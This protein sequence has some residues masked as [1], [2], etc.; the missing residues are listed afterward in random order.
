MET[1]IVAPIPVKDYPQNW[2]DF[3]DWFATE[4]ACLDYLE[5]LRWAS[6]FVCPS[7]G[8]VAE[9]Y[10][11]EFV[12]RFNQRTSSSRG[13]LFYRLLQQAVA[14]K[15]VTYAQVASSTKRRKPTKRK[16][17]LKA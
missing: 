13:M 4:E 5:K 17:K 3:L 1:H 6:G 15:P 7:C 14:T 10:L 8:S 16:T 11:D 12:F 9:A 2:N